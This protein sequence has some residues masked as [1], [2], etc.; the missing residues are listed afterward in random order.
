MDVD[1]FRKDFPEFADPTKFPK[2]QV[3]VWAAAGE[4]LVHATRYGDLRTLA[5][6]LFTAHNLTLSARAAIAAAAGG[7]PGAPPSV[8]S[9]KSVGGVSVSYD[10]SATAGAAGEGLF[11]AT[12]YG[13][14]FR[15]LARLFGAGGVVA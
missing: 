11:A 5:V 15:D 7:I 13:Q 12:T 3:E 9:S 14:R 8:A 4:K 10:T 1:V 6:Q 2:H